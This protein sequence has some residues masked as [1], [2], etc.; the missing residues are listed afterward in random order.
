[1]WDIVSAAVLFG[2]PPDRRVRN[3]LPKGE[4]HHD[5]RS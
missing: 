5:I 2:T 3:G 4:R 1:M